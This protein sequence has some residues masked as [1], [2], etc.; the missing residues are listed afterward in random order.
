MRVHP[1]LESKIVR[2][3]SL[4]VMAVVFLGAGFSWYTR[5][6]PEVNASES[7]V[8]QPGDF[9]VKLTELGELR[10]LESVTISAQKDLPIIYLVPEGKYVNEGDLL[11]RF[12]SSK[13][14]AAL[15]ESVA[16]MQVA[17]AEARKAERVL[18]AQREK[19][20]A[21]IA[22]YR[23]E[24]RIAQL[25]L[26]DLKRKPLPDDLVKA[27]M[28]LDRTKVALENATK[29]RELL[30]DF[31]QKG[32]ITKNTLEEAELDYLKAKADLQSAQFNY[33]KVA[34]GAT[35]QE[36]EK[37]Q[38]KLNQAKF[39]LEKALA[40]MDKELQSYEATI[41][42]EKANVMRTQ[43]LIKKAEVK[44]DRTELR[45]PT[46]GIVVYAF[47]G[48]TKSD[49]VQLGMVPFEGQP[50][51]Y[52]PD[53]STIVVDT[54]VNEID[55]GKVELGGKV[56]IRMEAY[57]DAVFH[58]T[59]MQIGSLAKLKQ[60]PTGTVSGIK[61]FDVTVKIEA[62]DARLRP[63]LTATLDFIVDQQQNV[64]SIP[65]SA[66]V[67][68]G[69]EHVVMLSKSGKVVERR[70]VLGT[71]NQHRVVVREGL[72]PGEHILLSPHFAG[73]S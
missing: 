25:D 58:G 19:M 51:L 39:A 48:E 31:V 26:D 34:A 49:K 27:Q 11:V 45:A 20:Q 10:A 30:P 61:V 36:L 63:G 43:R 2:R 1:M 29:K 37:A 54:E 73:V 17:E 21:D 57:P 53:L 15:E 13:Y 50:I 41:E 35:P 9:T 72:E 66:V 67:A 52:L 71:S 4:A 22:R 3:M 23:V 42:R 38:I 46:D 14:E 28:E 64:L 18:E 7:F 62:Q 33:D 68:R 44:L 65:L 32:F 5:S 16:G 40:G 6:A 24:A 69:T 70:V 8:V 60:S 59:V 56:E 47:V 55:I 12:D